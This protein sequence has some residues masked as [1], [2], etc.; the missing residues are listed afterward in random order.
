MMELR[1]FVLGA[2]YTN[3]FDTRR[4]VVAN[5]EIRRASWRWAARLIQLSLTLGTSPAIAE[6]AASAQRPMEANRIRCVLFPGISSI[7]CLE[8]GGFEMGS[9]SKEPIDRLIRI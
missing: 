1:A 4:G 6:K 8:L 5:R 2:F 3:D 7:L 9:E